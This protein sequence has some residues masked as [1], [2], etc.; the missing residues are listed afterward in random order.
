M[1]GGCFGLGNDGLDVD[2]E[3]VDTSA[4]RMNWMNW[5]VVA[6]VAVVVGMAVVNMN[7]VFVTVAVIVLVGLLVAVVGL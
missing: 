4:N 6:A 3:D 5:G 7:E 1:G 2:V